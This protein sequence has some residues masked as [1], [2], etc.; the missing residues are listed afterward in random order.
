MV[1]ILLPLGASVNADTSD[2]VTA[3]ATKHKSME[4]LKR[5]H[6]GDEATSVEPAVNIARFEA[7]RRRV[8]ERR[9]VQSWM[10]TGVVG[11]VLFALHFFKRKRRRG[12][13][14]LVVSHVIFSC[15]GQYS[16]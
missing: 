16:N 8:V 2:I 10:T 4:K 3:A 15:I 12:L 9:C 14:E 6:H 5:Y 13:K 7:K 1:V 11:F